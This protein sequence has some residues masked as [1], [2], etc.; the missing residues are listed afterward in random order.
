M[1]DENL[2]YIM[3]I[4]ILLRIALVKH[5]V[6][7]PFPA[8]CLRA[9]SDVKSLEWNHQRA[10]ERIYL[11][12]KIF[13]RYDLPDSIKK[14]KRRSFAAAHRFAWR[15]Y[16]ESKMYPFVLWHLLLD[17]FYSPRNGWRKRLAN[18]KLI[19]FGNRTRSFLSQAASD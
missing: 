14:L 12:D 3:D 4:D 9:H 15:C 17:I 11:A 7:I 1:V 18:Y 6:Y 16:G 5:P 13:S 19:R 10:K 2:R 8:V